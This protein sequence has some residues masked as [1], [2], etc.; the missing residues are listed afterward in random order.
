MRGPRRRHWR[1]RFQIKEACRSSVRRRRPVTRVGSGRILHDGLRRIAIDQR[2]QVKRMLHATHLMLD[3]EQHFAA[4]WVDNVL[5]AILMLVALLRD[6]PLLP[7]APMRPREVI[8]VDLEMVLVIRW[9]RTVSL[10]EEQ[11]LPVTGRDTSKTSR[12]IF[13]RCSLR[14]HELRI[15]SRDP[16][17]RSLGHVEFNIGNPECYLAE[18]LTRRVR[19]EAVSPWTRR[20]NESVALVAFETSSVEIFASLRQALRQ[21]FTIRHHDPD[22]AAQHLRFAGGQVELAASHID[23]HVGW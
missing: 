8:D 6:Q 1:R 9:N 23:P 21:G 5:E 15:E 3:R 7:Q 20:L 18:A 11:I 2:P 13:H 14:A 19:A 4:V 12:L 17:G 10:A 16:I 22:M